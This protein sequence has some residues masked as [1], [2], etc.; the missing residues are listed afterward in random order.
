MSKD[1]FIGIARMRSRGC[2]SLGSHISTRPQMMA[3]EDEPASSSFESE[4]RG[5]SGFDSVAEG[6]GRAA[7]W[8][9]SRAAR[10]SMSSNCVASSVVL[11]VGEV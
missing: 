4:D 1:G 8:I 11:D 7:G 2:T 9:S 6:C 5:R 3:E 10:S